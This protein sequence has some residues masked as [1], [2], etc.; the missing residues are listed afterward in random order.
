[1]SKSLRLRA[2]YLLDQTE[3]LA[4]AV[5][6]GLVGN[7]LVQVPKNSASLGASWSA[8]G[9]FVLTPRVRWIGAQFNDDANQLRLTAAVVA[10][11]SV[12]RKLGAHAQLFLAVENLGNTQIETGLS[13]TGLIST[14]EPRTTFGGIR[15]QL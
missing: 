6:P 8:P 10:D 11:L 14:G 2:D 9:A 7:Q 5:A 13:T 1:V 4:A 3:I 12:T 15:L